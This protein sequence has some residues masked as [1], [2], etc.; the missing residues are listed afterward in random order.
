MALEIL[1]VEKDPMVRDHLKVGLNQF[2]EFS[3]TVGTGYGGV[4]HL[5]SQPYDCVFLGIDQDV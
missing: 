4:N 2:A 5:R 3:I 1:L